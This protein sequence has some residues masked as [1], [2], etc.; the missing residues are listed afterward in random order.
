MKTVPEINGSAK[1]YVEQ[2]N[3]GAV[4]RFPDKAAVGQAMGSNGWPNA[5]ANMFQVDQL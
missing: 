4:P 2:R 5:E 1:R 3:I